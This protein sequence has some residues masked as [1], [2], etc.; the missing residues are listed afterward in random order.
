MGLGKVLAR[1]Q[2]EEGNA[3]LVAT[4]LL[5]QVFRSQVPA[6]L[7]VMAQGLMGLGKSTTL[8][9]LR[10][11]LGGVWVNQDEVAWKFGGKKARQNFLRVLGE[12]SRDPQ[13]PVILIDK[14]NTMRMHRND[15]RKAIKVQRLVLLTFEHPDDRGTGR[16]DNAAALALE[17]IRGRGQAHRTLVEG[18]AG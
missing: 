12:A 2:T 13:V 15:I 10:N 6:Q 1:A 8:K 4:M 11:L 14:I 9:T 18:D 7:Q 17:R 16:W 5:R 3:A